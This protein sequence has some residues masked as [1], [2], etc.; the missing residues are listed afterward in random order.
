MHDLPVTVKGRE[1]SLFR[2]GFVSVKLRT[3]DVS[4][5]IQPSRKFLNLQ[6]TTNVAVFD[7]K[8]IDK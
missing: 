4:R 8:M 3:D 2:N 5:K 6:Y 1:I 7:I